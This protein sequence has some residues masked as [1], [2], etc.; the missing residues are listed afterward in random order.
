MV[1]GS[2][3]RGVK[4]PSRPERERAR[5]SDDSSPLPSPNRKAGR[6]AGRTQ[7]WKGGRQEGRSVGEAGRG[8]AAGTRLPLLMTPRGASGGG[9]S[10]DST[11]LVRRLRSERGLGG[12]PGPTSAASKPPPKRLPPTYPPTH[13]PSHYGP[14]HPTPPHP[15]SL[16][17]SLAKKRKRLAR[18][19]LPACPLA[20]LDHLHVPT[21]GSAMVDVCGRPTTYANY[22]GLV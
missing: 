18:P 2:Q 11:Y 13:P 22:H 4:W 8:R 15:R 14:P 17:P 6:P 9:S 19:C 1:R 10:T 7:W 5:G 16:A 3:S 20:G 12:Q 21:S